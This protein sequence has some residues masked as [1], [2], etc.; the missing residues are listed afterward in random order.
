MKS[1]KLSLILSLIFSLYFV[2][3]SSASIAECS[4]YTVDEI[5]SLIDGIISY[6]LSESG[7]GSVSEWKDNGL[8]SGA[9]ISSEWYIMTLS[10]SGY[11]DFSSYEKALI[12]YLDNNST[13][14]ASSRLKYA[15]AL[16]ASGSTSS[17]INEYLD[18]SSGQQGIMSWIYS[19]HVIN[20]GYSSNSF[21]VSSVTDALLSLQ[22]SDG[23]WAL[24]GEYG[25]V[26]VTAMTICA[27]A[28][29]YYNIQSVNDAVNRGLDFL[30][31]RQNEDGGYS[32]FGTENSESASQVLTA[33]SSI[34]IDC[35]HDDRFIKN[36][37]T[38]IDGIVKFRDDNGGFHHV[39]DGGTNETA[40]NQA[41][42]SM[43]SYKMMTEGRFPF[44]V[45]HTEKIQ[46]PQ[47]NGTEQ[48]S[49]GDINTDIPDE[50]VYTDTAKVS[51]AVSVTASS[52]SQ[53]SEISETTAVSECTEA[54]SLPYSTSAVSESV[55]ISEFNED[56]ETVLL[57]K[58]AS[59]QK[60]YKKSAIII[61]FCIFGGI[62]LIFFFT[63]KRNPKNFIFL[64]IAAGTV[65]LFIIL[66]D[67]KSTDSYYSG[68]AET[69]E[70]ITGTVSFEIRCDT[71]AGK[72]DKDTIPEDGIILE[73]DNYFIEEGY[74][75]YDIL[76]E[77]AR[78]NKILI[79]SKGT[80]SSVYIAGINN[81]YELEF[82]DLSGWVYHV[83]GI[84]PSVG[85]GEY[86]VK[87]G[88][89]IEWLYT[90]DLGRDLGE[91]YE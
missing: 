80:S 48:D 66:T 34:G 8:V 67:F 71:I 74:T 13:E 29:Y 26:D 11:T 16:I 40:T 51:S 91:V 57:N 65:T 49:S 90:C 63:G 12:N 27:L 30:S 59:A 18:N 61:T 85:C 24:F 62:A 3:C 73:R 42:Y 17:Y 5:Q 64:L 14:S 9:G 89:K 60:N 68:T 76:N 83:N 77:A 32:S 19:L 6:K 25:D 23:G 33:L 4:E 37:N 69:K 1:K 46:T 21:N 41:L 10:Q 81:I 50:T 84:T 79:D 87:D 54:T 7:A 36:G 86:T 52:L 28:P 44:F 2:L 55:F 39:S 56:S 20:N 82:G 38:V 31:Q 35:Q 53:S 88:D 72:S 22:L 45:F 43:T 15:L 70:N 78:K 47:Q 58:T 75:V